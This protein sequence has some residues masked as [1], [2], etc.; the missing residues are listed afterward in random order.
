MLIS[1]FQMHPR[2]FWRSC[3]AFIGMMLLFQPLS[4]AKADAAPDWFGIGVKAALLDSNPATALAAIRIPGAVEAL[5]AIKWSSQ[6]ERTAVIAILLSL[7]ER[8]PSSYSDYNARIAAVDGLG[9]IEIDSPDAR[10]RAFGA[11]LKALEDLKGLKTSDTTSGYLDKL[12]TIMA[13]V[14]PQDQTQRIAAVNAL[15][16]IRPSVSTVQTLLDLTSDDPSQTTLVI[17]RVFASASDEDLYLRQ[18][19]YLQHCNDLTEPAAVLS[20]I[21]LGN[22]K[23][24]SAVLDALLR[25]YYTNS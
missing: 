16:E 25:Y 3:L 22:D 7:A 8:T 13:R 15:K 14:K 10:R 12:A 18:R 2:S 5:S 9:R 23:Q 19:E 6:T 1:P 17:D 11:S 21:R 20:D 24:T 4:R